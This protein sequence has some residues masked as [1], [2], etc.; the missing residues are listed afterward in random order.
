MPV[1]A[2]QPRALS[3]DNVRFQPWGA[4]LPDGK[5]V[6]IAGTEP[7]HGARLYVRD[8]ESGGKA[9]AV[10]PT[11]I[12]VSFTGITVS[13]DGKLVT[14]V[15]PDG[16]AAIFSIENGQ[17]RPIRGLETGE[18][19]VQ[20]SEDGRSLYVLRSQGL[21]AKLIALDLETGQRT[22]WKEIAPSDPTGACS[23]I[24]ISSK[25]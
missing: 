23:P 1:G 14:A 6:L 10:I 19:P 3:R 15:L 4:W 25:A 12:R 17:S 13:P 2:G 21:P 8:L 22:P 16:S 5:R 20:W 24:S 11:D 18:R 9:H 7:A